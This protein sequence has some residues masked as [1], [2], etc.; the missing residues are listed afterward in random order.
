MTSP[1][2]GPAHLV[3]I[4]Q[5]TPD[6]LLGPAPPPPSLDAVN[7]T[8]ASSTSPA[9]ASSIAAGSTVTYRSSRPACQLVNEAYNPPWTSRVGRQATALEAPAP[10]LLV[11]AK[12][13]QTPIVVV[14][15]QSAA[16]AAQLTSGSDSVTTSELSRSDGAG[17][18]PAAPA[19]WDQTWFSSAFPTASSRGASSSTPWSATS[20]T[21]DPVALIVRQRLVDG[22]K[23]KQVKM[24]AQDGKGGGISSVSIQE[25][26]HVG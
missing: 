3:A 21:D 7:V 10:A 11:A 6:A 14:I 1:A 5:T 24:Y 12:T 2:S 18:M 15:P 17:S 19:L 16:A 22:G 13:G 9:T 25:L 26:C 23:F 8:S 20:V 4:G